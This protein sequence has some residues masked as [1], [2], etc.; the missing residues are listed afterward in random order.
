M[1]TIA[2]GYTGSSPPNAQGHAASCQVV[3]CNPNT[4]T[5][6]LDCTEYGGQNAGHSYTINV[7]PN[8]AVNSP[9]TTLN[10]GRVTSVTY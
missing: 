4:G 1:V 6:T 9:G 5:A 7:S 3:A 2:P 10:G 8:G